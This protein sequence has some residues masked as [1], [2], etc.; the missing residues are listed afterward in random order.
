MHNVKGR[1]TELRRPSCGFEDNI[2][3]YLTK[4]LYE[5]KVCIHLVQ[6]RV[7]CRALMSMYTILCL[8]VLPENGFVMPKHVGL[9]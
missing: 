4:V 1:N 3:T 6:D 9:K 7:H 8:D 5:A 2:K